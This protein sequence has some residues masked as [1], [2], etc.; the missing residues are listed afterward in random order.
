MSTPLPS[1]SSLL[2]GLLALERTLSTFENGRAALMFTKSSSDSLITA[3]VDGMGRLVSVSITPSQLSLGATALASKVAGVINLAIDA[4]AASGSAAMASLASALSLPGLPAQGSSVPDYPDFGTLASTLT[5]QILANNPCQSSET[6]S[7]RAGR[8][9]ALVDAHRRVLSLTYEVLP[10]F[11]PHLESRTVEAVNCAIDHATKRP[12]DTGDATDGILDSRGLQDLVIYAKGSLLLDD[13]VKVKSIGCANFGTI[14]NSGTVETNIGADAQVGNV[15][16]RAHVVVRDRGA[17]HGFIHTSDVVTTQS[18][19]AIDGPVEEHAVVILPDLTLVVPFP[20]V[21]QGTIELEPNQQQTAAPGYYNQLHPKSGAQVFLSSGTYYFNDLFLEPGS[22]VWLDAGSG[23]IVIWVKNSF[24]FRGEFLDSASGFPR[25]FVGYLG[26]TMATVETKYKGTL[27]A[28]NAKINISTIQSHEGAFHGLNIEVQPDCQICHHPFE[29]RYDQLPGVGALPPPVVDLGFENVSG[30]SSAQALL[31]SVANPVTQ[32]S[33]SLQISNVPGATDIVSAAFSSN[34]APQGCAR[35]LVDLWVPS[36]QPNPTNFGSLTPSISIPSASINALSLGS[37]GLTSAPQN[38]FSQFEFPLPANVRTALD[39]THAD[40]SLKLSLGINAN[41][42]PWFVD[43]VRFELPAAALSTL[44]PILSF[45]DVTK[46]SSTQVALTSSTQFKTHLTKSLRIT[47][48]PG[49]VQISSV[50]FS[51]D[52]LSA[53]LGKFRID[54]YK[55]AN[56]PNPGW[57]GQFQLVIDVPSAGISGVTSSPVELTP[58]ASNTFSLI[59]LTLPANVKAVLNADY[60]DLKLK[61]VL[62][63]NNGSGPWH[64]DNIRFV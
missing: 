21:L 41:S 29:L 12:Q 64:L 1:P 3:V 42:G 34:L 27:S 55:P 59:E 46:W 5:T 31:T 35:L 7:C 57:H 44:D 28:P 6:F 30:W 18:A 47:T 61:L 54:L 16:S 14:G 4:A 60:A 58:L 23:P 52:P 26:T 51:T 45:E 19:P 13:R 33:R 25:V 20:S 62:N 36:N 39:G 22:K 10:S 8:V 48:A 63:V 40:V 2:S 11:V 38:K 15:I 50:P 17:V 56:Q 9:V 49:Q 32:G 37:L 43:N 24:T 53:P